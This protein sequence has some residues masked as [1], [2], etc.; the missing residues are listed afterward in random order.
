VGKIQ[1]LLK[2]PQFKSINLAQCLQNPRAK[3]L[4]TK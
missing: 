1:T 4:F 2:A 3:Q